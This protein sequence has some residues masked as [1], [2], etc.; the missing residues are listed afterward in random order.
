[1]GSQIHRVELKVPNII[2]LV[3]KMLKAGIMEGFEYEE[4]VTL[5]MHLISQRHCVLSYAWLHH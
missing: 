5:K 2:R 3:R 1:M 4:A